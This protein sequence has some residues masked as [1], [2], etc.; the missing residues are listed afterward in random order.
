MKNLQSHIEGEWFEI[1]TTPYTAEE[2]SILENDIDE[3]KEA[4]EA[5]IINNRDNSKIS[6]SQEDIILANNAYLKNRPIIPQGKEYS[7]INAFFTLNGLI[8]TGIINCRIDEEHK[9]IRF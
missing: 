3:N 7:L 8:V 1:T 2:L 6:A 9:Q 4:I 5:I